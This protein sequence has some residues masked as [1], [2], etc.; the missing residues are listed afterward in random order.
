MLDT[1]EILTTSGVVLWSRSYAQ[2]NPSVINSFIADVF[3]EENSSSATTTTA[4]SAT[5][6]S[7]SAATNAPYNS[8]PHTL[9]WA[10][11]KEL[12]IIFVA[13]YRSLLHL[14][15]I[16]KLVDNIKTIFAKLYGEQLKR[17]NTTIVECS[18]FDGYFD[19]QLQEL[20]GTERQD[21][22]APA[23]N[24]LEEQKSVHLLEVP[25]ERM[26]IELREDQSLD[27]ITPDTSRPTTPAEP[28][29]A[30]LSSGQSQ[31]LMA[32]GGQL[33]KM[34][35]RARKTQQAHNTSALA[36]SGDESPARKRGAAGK[37]TA[38]KGRKWN[39]DGLADEDDGVQLDYSAAGNGDAPPSNRDGPG[40]AVEEVDAATWG[41]RQKGK[42]VLRDLG[43][44]VHG[45][46]ADADAEAKARTPAVVEKSGLVSSGLSS[47]S[48]LFRNVVGG[49]TL[50]KED[51]EKPMRGMEE[52]LL[53]KNVAREAAVR[54]CEGVAK[55]LVGVKTGG[56][57]SK[58]VAVLMRFP[59]GPT[60][61]RTQASTP[62]SDLQWKL[63]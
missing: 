32:K 62:K 26:N 36:S 13:V 2:V 30:G 40:Q 16:D 41:Q 3:I 12:G 52:H 24:G 37:T 47:I 38:K 42:F 23:R 51:L 20:E 29:A 15:W 19:Q 33:G 17:P 54:L 39:A 46:L 35:R 57:E 55:E 34:S 61:G 63:R 14:S 21:G 6:Q 60:D 56:F 43:D 45:I 8:P 59:D 1:F 18:G 53:K 22:D 28:G 44:E 31:L 5:A 58:S 11:N 49:K 10:F 25:M 27:D 9:R 50:T 4:A 7:S 48:G